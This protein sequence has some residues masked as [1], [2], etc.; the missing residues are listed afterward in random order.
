MTI[1]KNK[2]YILF[3]ALAFLFLPAQVMAAPYLYVSHKYNFS[4]EC[5]QKPL[6]VLPLLDEGHPGEMLVFKNDGYTIL[7]AWIIST[8]AFSSKD[9][10]DFDKMTPEQEK[11]YASI[12]AANRGYQEVRFVPLHGKKIIYAVTPKIVYINSEKNG[13]KEKIAQNVAQRIEAYVPGQRTNYA[14]VFMNT[15]AP[16]AAQIDAYQEGL[17]SFKELNLPQAKPSTKPVVSKK[18]KVSEKKNV[19]EQQKVA[20]KAAPAAENDDADSTQEPSA[21]DQRKMPLG[22]NISQ[23]KSDFQPVEKSDV[24]R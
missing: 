8:N 7:R 12:L 13:K 3:A 23:N 19:P 17:L 22:K 24:M 21:V 2:L 1:M 15:G 14:I 9:M 11:D 20:P 16:E 4:I 5:P 10:P 6:G 18:A